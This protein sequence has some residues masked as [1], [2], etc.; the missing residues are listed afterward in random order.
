MR[1]TFVKPS[2]AV[3]R[4][5]PVIDAF[6]RTLAAPISNEREY[7]PVSH[8]IG[9]NY[10]VSTKGLHIDIEKKAIRFKLMGEG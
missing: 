10:T 9:T 5:P 8:K 1:Q 7:Y 4:Y 6:S 2:K 3:S